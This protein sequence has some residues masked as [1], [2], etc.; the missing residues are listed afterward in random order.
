MPSVGDPVASLV[1]SPRRRARDAVAVE[2]V[3]DRPATLAVEEFAED[4]LDDLGRVFVEGEFSESVA[5]G[6][7]AGVGV[8]RR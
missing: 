8:R 2:S 6:G 5:F 1:G 3:G 4:A 7:F